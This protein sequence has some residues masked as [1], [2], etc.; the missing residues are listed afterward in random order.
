MKVRPIEVWAFTFFIAI[1]AV[2]ALQYYGKAPATKPD[3]N[4]PYTMSVTV[5]R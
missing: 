3:P 5:K 2:V 1:G 4:A